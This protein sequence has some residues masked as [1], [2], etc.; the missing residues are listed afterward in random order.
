MEGTKVISARVPIDI[1]KMVDELCKQK[2][3]NKSQFISQAVTQPNITDV[4]NAKN[5]LAKGSSLQA[6]EELN[7]ILKLI[8]TLGGSAGAGLLIY[9]GLKHIIPDDRF[10]AETKEMMSVFGAIGGSLAT[11]FAMTNAF[12]K[13]K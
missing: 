10:D 12:N 8:A 1:A 6:P 11:F 3:I 9:E 2:K 7:E 4:V 5:K 13:D